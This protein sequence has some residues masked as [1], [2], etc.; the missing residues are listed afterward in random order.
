MFSLRLNPAACGQFGVFD[1]ERSVLT[2]QQGPTLQ[3]ATDPGVE[4]Q[5]SELQRDDSEQSEDHDRDPGTPADQAIERTVARDALQELEQP[6]RETALGGDGA[7]GGLTQ[8]GGAR[9]T[10]DPSRPGRWHEPPGRRECAR[11]DRGS[12]SGR[13]RHETPSDV[14]LRAARSRAEP[15]RGLLATSAEEGTIERRAISAA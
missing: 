7:R 9:R 11:T 12:S 6:E 1:A 4:L 5:Q 3:R 15:A 10:G 14:S 13:R 2:L 8:A